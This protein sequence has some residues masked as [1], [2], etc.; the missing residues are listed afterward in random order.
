MKNTLY[1][2]RYA[3]LTALCAMGISANAAAAPV[4]SEL[5]YDAVGTDS[6][7]TFVELFG[8]PGEPLDGMMLEGING[9]GGTV[10]KSVALS[11]MVPPDGVFVI[12]DDSG[13]GTAVAHADLVAD[14]DLQNG[15][16][17]LVL[18]ID[19]AILDAV[20]YGQFGAG[21]VFAGEGAAAP[22]PVAGSSIARF[23]PLVDSQD[24]SLDFIVLDMPTP[25]FVPVG[26][27]VP[28]PAAGWLF[29]SGLGAVLGVSR[30]WRRGPPTLAA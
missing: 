24:N 5:F 20:G 2:G 7:V 9:T 22:D 25:G 10:Y 28:L 30:R 19:T 4:I 1:D 8:V 17:S 26:S 11:G 15:P 27:V 16:D 14:I 21:D 6:G 12:G 13:A 18:R 23:Y 3:L 29:L